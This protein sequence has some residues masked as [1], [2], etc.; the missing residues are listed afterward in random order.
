MAWYSY[1]FKDIPQLLVVRTVK[2]FGI[3]NE[4]E[5]DVFLDFP[6]FL[7]DATDVGNFM[8]SSSTFS[9]P[10]LYLEVLS[11]CSVEV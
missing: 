8:S 2:G 5:V 9:K 1:L 7:C 10:S 3:V 11:S 4:A 6:C